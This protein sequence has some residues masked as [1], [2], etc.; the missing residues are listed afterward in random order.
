VV[1]RDDG[2]LVFGPTSIYF[3][4]E[5]D[6]PEAEQEALRD[7]R[8]PVLDIGAGAGRH[9]LVVQRRGIATTAL[10]TSPG[11]IRVCSDRGVGHTHL[12]SLDS[13]VHTGGAGYTTFLLLGRNLGLLTR[14]DTSRGLLITLAGIARPGATIVGS[15]VDPGLPPDP[16]P[17]GDG[18]QDTRSGRP[19]GLARFRVRYLDT[20]T[21]WFEFRFMSPAELLQTIADTPWVVDHLWHDTPEWVVRLRLT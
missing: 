17:P 14:A 19:R 15:S 3:A 11:A 16:L 8:G 7:I 1:E 6:W 12:G 13:L 2:M 10:D 21:P 4:D 5:S 9:S 18:H 20:A